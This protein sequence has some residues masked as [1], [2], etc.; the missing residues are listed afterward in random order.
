MIAEDDMA[1]VPQTLRFDQ[2][3]G[4]AGETSLLVRM[5]PAELGHFSG[6]GFMDFGLSP[7]QLTV[8][9]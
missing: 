9:Q 6:M 5:V 2:I 1:G 7:Q 3:A 8:H 4:C